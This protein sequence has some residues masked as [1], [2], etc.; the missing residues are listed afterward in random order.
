LSTSYPFILDINNDNN[1]SD[2][3][4]FQEGE[5]GQDEEADDNI[6]NFIMDIATVTT[7]TNTSS[8]SNLR[9]NNVKKTHNCF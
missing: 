1:G 4:W 9:Q 3:W 5:E 6:V 7:P 8:S 2:P